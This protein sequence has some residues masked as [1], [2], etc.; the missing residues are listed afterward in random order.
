[1][2][3]FPLTKASAVETFAENKPGGY[4]HASEVISQLLRFFPADLAHKLAVLG[5]KTGF[6]GTLKKWV[7]SINPRFDLSCSVFQNTR[8][9]HP[10]GLAAGFDKNAEV[11][12]QISDLGFSF[13]EVGTVTPEAQS[14]NPGKKLFRLP[15]QRAIVNRCGFN[16]CG[17][18]KAHANLKSSQIYQ[19]SQLPLGVNLG[20][21]KQTSIAK[22]I[23]DYIYLAAKFTDCASYMVL[24]I[25][26][27]NTANLRTLATPSFIKQISQELKSVLPDQLKRVWIKLDPDLHKPEY[28]ALVEA[29][30]KHQFAGLILTNTQKTAIPVS[31]GL[32]GHPLAVA[33]S[34]RLE[35][36]YQ[37][38]KGELPMI[39][40]GGIFSGRDIYEKI[41]RGANAVQIYT[42]LI[43]RGPLAVAGLLSELTQ[44]MDQLGVTH[45]DDLRYSY[46]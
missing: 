21:N 29:I 7:P 11:I 6:A 22:A 9:T 4:I 23:E 25:S 33:S 32:S 43:Y 14:G 39:G 8:L 37:V 19:K 31:G 42:S 12:D 45:L 28:T 10:I 35:W 30:T 34:S 5:L 1:M 26:S 2:P 20:K 13:M 38:H 36:A 46:Y 16:N 41:I 24:N 17:A 3:S 44:L 27:P 15:S 40:V 18:N